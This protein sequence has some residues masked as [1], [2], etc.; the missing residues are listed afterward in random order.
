MASQS[1]ATLENN[2]IK[3][4]IDGGYEQISIKDEDELESNF[5]HQLEKFNNTTFKDDEFKKILIHLEGGSIFEKA[6]KLRDQYELSRDEGTFYVKFL[7]KQEWCKNI[8]Q[9]AN[10]ITMKGKYENRYD[11]TILI[12]GLPLVQIE[13]K[14]RGVEL[15]NAF[16]QIQR[17][18][19]HSFHNLFNYVQIFVISNGV[20]TKFFSNNSELN[21]NFTFFWKDKD[22][23]NINNL[24]DFATTFLEKCHLSKMISQYIVLNETKKSLMILRAYQYYAVESIL[25]SVSNKSNGYV[26]HTTGSGKTLTSFKACQILAGREDIDKVM[27]IVDRNDLDYQT[28][29]E[30]NS[31][32]AGAVD[33]TDN[34]NALIKQLKGQN[35]LIITTIQKLHR[36]VKV[37]AKQLE[38]YRNLRMVLMFDECHRSQFGDMHNDITGFFNDICCYGFT[39]TP[40][41][42]E[43]ANNSRTTQDLFGKC[44][45][46]YLIKDA[47]HDENVL[48]F[49]VD[50]VG[51]YKSRVKTDI[52]VEDIDTKEVM[53]SEE[54]L[55]KIVDYIIK[56][57]DN[58][59]YHKEFTSMFCVS[60]V[61]VLNK[62][63]EIFK[64]K[65]SGLKIAAIYSYGDNVD[66]DDD[67]KHPRDNLESHIK[68]Y[69]NMFGTNFSTDDFGQYYVDV[70]KRSKN[71]QIDILLVVNMFLTGFDNPLLNTLYV[72]KNLQ[73][74]GL[75]QAFSRTNRVENIRKTQGNIVCFRNLKK[76][77]DEAIRLFSDNDASG[78]I[79]TLPYEEYVDKFNSCANRLLNLVPEVQDVDLLED[80]NSAE[81][82]VLTFK[83]ILRVLNR[84][85]TFAEFSY[86]DLRLTEQKI[87]DYKSKYLDL[88][89]KIVRKE[90]PA[91]SSILE[92][93]DFEI[94]L[95]R[96]D[97]INVSY[98]LTLLKELD[99]KDASFKK[100]VK[101]IHDLMQSSHELKS[102]AELI[103]KFINENIVESEGPIDIDE[104]LPQYFEKE[105]NKEIDELVNSENL[106]DE[107]T[108]EVIAEYE[109]S[110]KL[111]NDDIKHSFNEKL[112]FLERRHKVDFLK[113]KII[114]LVDKFALI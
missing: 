93:I 112:G 78:Y 111:R 37:R 1:E 70:S 26:W 38:N 74:H 32:S 66:L 28:T 72:D 34:T 84:M 75:I 17:Y 39:G 108:R 49:S 102:K 96:R 16:K 48:G 88:H 59:T 57:H 67:K 14:K 68:D 77:T 65:N 101:L 86:D 41:F 45:H 98:I 30:F 61:P 97:N 12:N 22:N 91:K 2:L 50:Y 53:E 85:T 11:V 110:G 4:L 92:D 47:I 23:R 73:Y 114:D 10:Q 56:Y 80:E 52:E 95:T 27:F 69:N 58:K 25:E 31:F 21:Y 7:N 113:S 103:D 46:S 71:K 40:I 82:F 36:A 43:N 13:L 64:K 15:K 107:K 18:Q 24:E 109:Y 35:K 54:R 33:G 100:D 63:Y 42:A 20:N 99:P 62:Y 29:K 6:K 76:R 87:N 79:V 55:E 83:N 3:T 105:K 106:S 44:L 9:V 81:K 104:E 89:D 5:R 60:S 51:T 8:F 94:E 19:L 90:S